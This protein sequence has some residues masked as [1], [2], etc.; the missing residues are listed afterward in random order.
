[1]L[2]TEGLV[3]AVEPIRFHTRSGV[4]TCTQAGEMIELDFPALPLAE[5]SPPPGLLETLGIRPTLV[6]RS[7]SDKFLVVGS[8]KAVRSLKPN[9]HLLRSIPDMR[10]VIV[11][12]L[13][14]DHQFDFISRYFAPGAGVDED[15]VTGSSHCCLG[16]FWG[17]RLG[18]VELTG[19]QASSR[20]GIVRMRLCGDRVI[21]G[22]TAV[23]VSRGELVESSIRD[24][25]IPQSSAMNDK[26]TG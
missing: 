4:L 15:P 26:G 1:M 10:G 14:S 18:K 23:T 19:Y 25:A 20:G 7:T 22:G 21:L 3:P 9:F 24:V 13:S 16:P 12:S 5:A 6:G 11:T 2:W 17:E 8:E